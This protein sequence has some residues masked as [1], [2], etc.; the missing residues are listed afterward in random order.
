M[1]SAL[2]QKTLT[3][4][5]KL[6]SRERG[7]VLG[8]IAFVLCALMYNAYESASMAFTEQEERL[9]K[10]QEA[11]VQWL[12]EKIARYSSLKSKRDAFENRFRSIEIKQGVPS[13]VESIFTSKLGAAGS[14]LNVT[15]QASASLGDLF[16]LKPY[17]VRFNTTSLK[18]LADFLRELTEGEQPLLLKELDL[19]KMG[20]GDRLEVNLK[21]SSITAKSKTEPA[22]ADD[23]AGS[24]P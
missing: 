21:V 9:R 20:I 18:G 11:L 6:S 22:A 2:T 8:S 3:A 16:V 13:L 24:V 1:N 4:F 19:T 17:N 12:P 10:A 14:A 23:D 7:L 5:K 15:E